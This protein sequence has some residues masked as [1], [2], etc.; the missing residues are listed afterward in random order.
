MVG[1]GVAAAGVAAAGGLVGAAVGAAAGVVGLAAAV[2]VAA[3]AVVGVTAG[4]AGVGD[5]TAG[6][7]VGVGVGAAAGAQATSKVPITI[8]APTIEISRFSIFISLLF[9]SNLIG[10]KCLFP[11][12][13]TSHHKPEGPLSLAPGLPVLMERAR[14]CMIGIRAWASL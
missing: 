11:K 8:A 1:A 7:F 3:A 6:A 2:G 13:A 14:F 4:L 12:C 5:A 9:S 10:R